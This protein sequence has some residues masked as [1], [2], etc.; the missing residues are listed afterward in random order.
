[1]TKET[2]IDTLEKELKEAEAGIQDLI[3]AGKIPTPDD[4]AD[5]DRI[6]GKLKVARRVRAMDAK[7]SDPKLTRKVSILLPE[8]E[9]QVLT[10]EAKIVGEDLSKYIRRL[11]K[12][13]SQSGVEGPF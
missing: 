2:D 3:K 13:K 12:N 9:F 7:R 1:M 6:K 10:K 5:I 4:Y 11:L 8:D